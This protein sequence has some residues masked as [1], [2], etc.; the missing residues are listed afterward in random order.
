MYIC[1]WVIVI[2]KILFDQ[3]I[4]LK[5]NENHAFYTASKENRGRRCGDSMLVG[6]TTSCAISAYHH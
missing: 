5:I 6:L 1:T 4:Q 3:T 2:L